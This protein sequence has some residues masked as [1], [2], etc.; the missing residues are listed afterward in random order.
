MIESK[1]EKAY[2]VFAHIVLILMVLSV[3]L[4]F[5]LLF[6]SSI[7]DENTLIQNGY[8]FFPEKFSLAAYE[9]IVNQG[10]KV[11]RA[12]GITILVTVIGTFMNVAMSSML[13]YG[14]S[15]R[16]LPLKRVFSFYVFFTMLFNGGL[17]P[18]Y[19]MYTGTFH[20]GN[21]LL[22]LIV[23][24]FMLSAMNVILIRTF[25][26]SSIPEALYEA[27]EIDGAN[28]FQVFRNVV[29][30]LGKPILV[31]MG[32]FSALAYWNDWTNGLYYLS[33]T[34]GQEL[35]S[36]QNLLN[37]MMSQIEFLSTSGAASAVSSEISKVPSTSVRM[38][39][40]FVAMLPMLIIYPFLQKYFQKGIALGAVK[41]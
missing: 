19:M 17:V 35:Y 34:D 25:Y 11:L 29:L 5:L 36:I 14:L 30:P 27:A 31:T 21:T 39:I 9:Y 41:G 28:H 7:T 22:A 12:Y 13:A 4:P 26:N 40:A 20:I 37:Q 23:P 32:L 15:L 38:A 8:S 18:T 24:Q 2:Q 3:V 1:G 33:G 6:M 16:D 10:S